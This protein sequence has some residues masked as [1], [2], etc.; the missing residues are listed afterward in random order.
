MLDFILGQ[1]KGDVI[2]DVPLNSR[3]RGSSFSYRPDNLRQREGW[4]HSSAQLNGRIHQ[5][6]REEPSEQGLEYKATND[7]QNV[8]HSKLSNGL[9]E[10]YDTRGSIDAHSKQEAFFSALEITQSERC[11]DFF[12]E[13]FVDIMAKYNAVRR[14]RREIATALECEITGREAQVSTRREDLDRNLDELRQ[15][16]KGVV[17]GKSSTV[18]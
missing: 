3:Q 16:G 14:Q 8:A 12:I 4:N 7:F 13:R 1:G 10:L 2:K 5:Q 17:R 11:G 6:T 18:N 15:A 9:L